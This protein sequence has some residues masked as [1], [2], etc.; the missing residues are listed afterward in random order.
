MKGIGEQARIAVGVAVVGVLAVGALLWGVPSPPGALPAVGE[1]EDRSAGAMSAAA[2]PGIPDEALPAREVAGEELEDD[3]WRGREITI[4]V[5]EAGTG[6]PVPHADIWLRA[7]E[8][9]DFRAVDRYEIWRNAFDGGWGYRRSDQ[10]VST[11]AS[12]IATWNAVLGPDVHVFV[13][14]GPWWGAVSA[15]VADVL[16]SGEPFEIAVQPDVSVHLRVD[17]ARGVPVEGASVG[18]RAWNVEEDEQSEHWAR[19][20]AGPSGVVLR[21]LGLVESDASRYLEGDWWFQAWAAAPGTDKVFSEECPLSPGELHLQLAL[22]E[23]A[24]VDLRWL[25]A[26]GRPLRCAASVTV[27]PEGASAES[28]RTW[29][30]LVGGR[31]SFPVLPETRFVAQGIVDGG[32][33][34]FVSPEAGASASHE[35]RID[36]E[37]S[38]LAWRLLDPAGEPVRRSQ[39]IL[40]LSGAAATFSIA[41]AET[42]EHGDTQVVLD[43]EWADGG[44]DQALVEVLESG[45]GGQR[46]DLLQGGALRS[47]SHDL[48]DVQLQLPQLLV[49]G[50]VQPQ[51][52]ADRTKTWLRVERA[53]A[54]GKWSPV[55]L[56]VQWKDEAFEAHGL[57]SPGQYRV[58]AL[59]REG[60][61]RPSPWVSFEPGTT[62]LELSLPLGGM[63]EQPVRR[64]P[65]EEMSVSVRAVPLSG[66]ALA[67]DE[68]ERSRWRGG[69]KVA[70]LALPDSL[71]VSRLATGRYRFDVSCSASA[72][73]VHSFDVRVESAREVVRRPLLVLAEYLRKIEVRVVDAEGLPVAKA[74]ADVQGSG[75]RRARRTIRDGVLVLWLNQPNDVEVR[76]P[77]GTRHTFA[78]VATATELRLPAAAATAK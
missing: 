4:R 56:D 14:R 39:L 2:E 41:S 63:V 62:D 16:A 58:R 7:D 23:M 13:E 10:R 30:P 12:G 42:D 9:P 66:E 53:L 19:T 38:I 55:R 59:S 64:L 72:D 26:D 6:A 52:V 33:W 76:L 35:F 11:D 74:Y 3:S 67:A 57:A 73:I 20:V 15:E 40:H 68:A 27:Q 25:D 18:W 45:Y 34:Q 8:K 60:S 37:F 50:I 51:S 47:G 69:I 49:G 22:P 77:D 61:R 48:G 70:E 75:E 65:R 36:P 29:E 32:A 43:R 1:G 31:A 44:A 54:S 21:H 24:R 28:L 71:W 78:A 46:A 17:D 5:V